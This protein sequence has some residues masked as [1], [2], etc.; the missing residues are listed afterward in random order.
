MNHL[1]AIDY[2]IVGAYFVFAIA[3]GLFFSRRASRS[4]EDFFLGGRSLPW[5]A[6]GVSMVA[7]SFASDTPLVITELIR[8]H[9]IQRLWW[10]LASVMVL[11]VGIF[12][13]SRLWRRAEIITDAEFYELRYEGRPAAFLRGFRAFSSGVI[14]NVITMGFVIFGMKTIITT[15]TGLNEWLAIGICIA[16]ALTYA[17]AAGFYGVVVT[18]IIQFAI[19]TVSMIVLAIAGVHQAGGLAK[20]LD[21]IKEMPRYGEHTLAIFP[22]GTHFNNELVTIVV[23]LGLLWWSDSGGYNMQR[24]SACRNER[25]AVKATLFYAVF[26]SIRLWLWVPVALVSIVWF[27]VLDG[28]YSDTHA[29]PLVMRDALGP[30]LLGLLV[31]SFLA[32]FMST[33]DTHLNWGAS[34]LM[35]DVYRRFLRPQASHKEYMVATR[36]VTVGLMVAA[37]AVVPLMSSISRTMEFLAIVYVGYGIISVARWFWWRINAYTEIIATI[38]GLLFGVLDLFAATF[39]EESFVLFGTPWAKLDFAIKIA[40]LT[41]TVVP[42]SLVVTLLTPPVSMN[43]LENFYRKVRPG[44]AWGPVSARTKELP[45]RALT[46]TS[47]LDIAGGIALCYGLSVAIGYCLLLRFYAAC[48]CLGISVIGAVRVAHWYRRE[49]AGLDD[50]ESGRKDM[51]P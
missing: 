51:S 43:T 7:S 45:G 25:D 6:I 12:L 47:L 2:V 32:A 24:M 34:Y 22:D 16:V 42:I 35:N 8:E 9:G 46:W 19:A 38:L 44:G 37:A 21:T 49:I 10:I 33:I 39:A 29:Y 17:T 14:Q 50:G 26:Q 30:G 23:F 3:V 48:L 20:L 15:L 36:L 31:T 27:P 5:W 13:F 11:I 18:D 28:P 41:A 1:H 4:P 40:V